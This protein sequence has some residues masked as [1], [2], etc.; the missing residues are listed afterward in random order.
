MSKIERVI[1]GSALQSSAVLEKQIELGVEHSDFSEYG[2]VFE[3]MKNAF[4]QNGE[5]GI[6]QIG[7]MFPDRIPEFAQMIEEAPV[8][9]SIEHYVNEFLTQSAIK[10]ATTSLSNALRSLINRKPFDDYKHVVADIKALPE[11]FQKI[12]IDDDDLPQHAKQIVPK[13]IEDLEDSLTGKAVRGYE[14]GFEKF[15]ILTGGLKKGNYIVIAARSKVGKTSFWTSLIRQPLLEGKK[16][17]A[18]SIEM[19]GSQLLNRIGCAIAK[20][21]PE[22]VRDGKVD[23]EE[24][25]KYVQ[26]MRKLYR[27]NIIVYGKR[28]T[29]FKVIEHELIKQTRKGN[30][31]IA[32]IDYVQ[33]YQIDPKRSR[34]QDISEITNRIQNLVKTL[35]IPMIVIAQLNRKYAEQK[36]THGS[37]EG[38][39]Y[40]RDCGGIEQDADVIAVL[41]RDGDNYELRIEGNRFGQQMTIPLDANVNM[42]DFNEA[43]EPTGHK[44]VNV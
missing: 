15:D 41:D 34:F 18:F 43:K 39:A 35:N 38:M 33:R 14:T 1:I 32:V 23:D 16:I 24:R 44:G 7:L 37:T 22:K 26:A 2:D 12:K 25:D 27:T 5:Y 21:K 29:N 36:T 40:I 13:L 42:C 31:E 17:I 9:L 28:F 30:C 4:D 8:T 11:C 3:A 20:I 19:D 6:S 10:R